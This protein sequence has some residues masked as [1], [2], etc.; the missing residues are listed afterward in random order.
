MNRPVFRPLIAMVLCG[1]TSARAENYS[2]GSAADVMRSVVTTYQNLST[3]QDRGRSVQTS[4]LLKD[5]KE[6]SRNIIQ[7]TTLFKRGGRY[8]FAWTSRDNFFGKYEESSSN[9]FWSDGTKS[10]Y[11]E[12][13]YSSKPRI[14]EMSFSDASA[15]TT[16]VSQGTSHEIF[17]LLCN[18]MSGFRYDQ[19]R[20]LR[21]AGS[22]VVSGVD[23]NVVH[24]TYSDGS[25]LDLSIGKRDHLIRKGV[26]T[27]LDGTT[28]TFERSDIV[29]NADIPDSEFGKR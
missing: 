3:Y 19:L 18:E 4:M 5:E 11:S 20:D 17:R 28:T 2:A 14:S 8:R 22:E 7:F 26:H 1:L 9:R 10:W 27:W 13:S 23:S 24:G 21:I 29:V 25:S 16:G 6:T 12:S 15:A